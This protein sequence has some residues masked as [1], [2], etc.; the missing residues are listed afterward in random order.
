MPAIVYS[1]GQVWGHTRI[2]H[3]SEKKDLNRPAGSTRVGFAIHS[4]GN[5]G[6]MKFSRILQLS[7]LGVMSTAGIGIEGSYIPSVRQLLVGSYSGNLT[8]LFF[9]PSKGTLVR[10]SHN[11]E[12]YNPAWQTLF[13][14]PSGKKFILSTNEA[15]DVENSGLTVW[16]VEKD[17]TLK[18]ASKTPPG[19]VLA[20]PA[21]IAVRKDGLIAVA[22]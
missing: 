22:S 5:L 1:N 9:D 3:S 14:S 21:S 17:G 15:Y 11:A 7:L 10:S 4:I 18:F 16:E 6:S 20:G 19:A 8:T 13:T 2:W 12:S